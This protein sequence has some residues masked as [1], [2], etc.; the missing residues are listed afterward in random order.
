MT[1]APASVLGQPSF[2]RFWLA[3]GMATL[4]F[5]MQAV[6]VGWQVYALTHSALALGLVGL[7]QFLPMLVCTLPAGHLA[8]RRDRRVIVRNCQAV[9]AVSAALLALGAVSQ[10][11]NV[12]LIFALVATSA[13]ARAFEAPSAQAVVPGLVPPAMISRAMAW[14]A[15]AN[16]T[17][18]ILGPALGGLL[19]AVAP[20]APYLLAAL[21][22]VCA[23]V[24][25]SLVRL[26]RPPPREAATW[27]SMFSG[28]GFIFSRKVILGCISL[29][30]FAVLLGGASA[31]LPVFAHDILRTGPWGLG[32]LRSAPALGALTMSVV[33]ARRRITRHAGPAMFCA[34]AVFG[35]ATI[36][37]GLSRALP[38]SL[39]A[40]VLMGAADVVSV[41]IRQTLVQIGTPDAM[42]GR[43]AAVNT[44]FIGTSNQL[45]EFE[46]GV[47]AALFGTVPAV[48]LGGVGTVLVAAAWSGMF[49]E[50]RRMNTL[51]PAKPAAT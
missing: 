21:M 40:L 49:P 13:A 31:L 26:A 28:I 33:L 18:T 11:G 41:V 29:D 20:G 12:V 42:R 44:M 43:V 2:L 23:S 25:T 45:G 16:Q 36:V 6:A 15:S 34:V 3:R 19:Y 32:L 17:A 38:L 10:G 30:L 51:D 5:Q 47:T 39:L 48:V 14:S 9:A 35:V 8:D 27:R 7:A 50:L 46:S 24:L 1:E 4:A 22:Y 37:F